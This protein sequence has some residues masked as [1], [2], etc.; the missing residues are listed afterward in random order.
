VNSRAIVPFLVIVIA[1][2]AMMMF[3]NAQ[4]PNAPGLEKD[5]RIERIVTW[6]ETQLPLAFEEHTGATLTWDRVEVRVALGD[7]IPMSPSRFVARDVSIGDAGGDI[8]HIAQIEFAFR[9]PPVDGRRAIVDTIRLSG[10]YLDEPATA[11]PVRAVTVL[12]KLITRRSGSWIDVHEL[13]GEGVWSEAKPLRE[14]MA[15]SVQR[16]TQPGS[17]SY[18]VSYVRGASM[19]LLAV[20]RPIDDQIAVEALSLVAHSNDVLL[21][22][23]PEVWRAPEGRNAQWG[24]VG[25]FEPVVVDGEPALRVLWREAAVGGTDQDIA[26]PIWHRGAVDT[27]IST[28]PTSGNP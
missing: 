24:A 10:L 21:R 12:A 18:D 2:A 28:P 25:M 11:V 17:A 7:N 26:P 1:L 19:E 4:R 20:F 15:I 6:I 23:L 5:P 16:R 9:E 13:T 27:I 8:A 22:S 3:I 14:A